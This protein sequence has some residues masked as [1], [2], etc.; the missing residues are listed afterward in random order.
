MASSA[1]LSFLLLLSLSGMLAQNG[2]QLP[3]NLV[4]VDD[5]PN[6]KPMM[7]SAQRPSER[8]HDQA[9]KVTFG[10]S[11]QIKKENKFWQIAVNKNGTVTPVG[12]DNYFIQADDEVFLRFTTLQL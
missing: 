6:S 8:A 11:A 1:L 2:G 5:L 4:V 10:G 9:R 3:F 7:Y 12:L